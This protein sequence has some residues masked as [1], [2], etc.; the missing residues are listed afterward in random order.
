MN[1]YHKILAEIQAYRK[2]IDIDSIT[3]A[4]HYE[5]LPIPDIINFDWKN[6]IPPPDK[7]STQKTYSELVEVIN[8]AK[9][10]TSE[11][12]KFVSRID[13]DANSF[14]YEYLNTYQLNFPMDK[15]H[16][17][18]SICKPII[19]NIKFLFDRA[20][21]Y[22]L[23]RIYGF[24][25]NLWS[26]PTHKTP[27]YPSGHVFYTS[28]ATHFVVER[29]PKLKSKMKEIIGLTS[30]ARMMQGVHYFSDNV[31]GSKLADILYNKLKEVIYD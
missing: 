9:Q 24:D 3:Y 1:R 21:P 18:Y 11:E 14:L 13:V 30:Q 6:L 29:Y 7:N 20:R 12:T 26:S 27:S 17:M 23:S 10:R 22:Q 25:I 5:E 4:G 16:A 31:A 19:S 2:S 15:F 8:L 28:L